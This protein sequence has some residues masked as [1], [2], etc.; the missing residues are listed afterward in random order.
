MVAIA[1]LRGTGDWGADERPKDFREMILWANPNGEAPLTA[2]MSK[3]G[4]EKLS[5]PE[6]AWWEETLSQQRIEFNGAVAPAAA[7]ATVYAA[8][9][10]TG[11]SVGAL[12]LGKG[13]V[14]MVEKVDGTGELLYIS[15]DPSNDTGISITKG[16]SGT[17]DA[18]IATGTI[19]L[20]IGS[21]FEEG[22]LQPKA[23]SSNPTKLYN[24]AQIF[25]TSYSITES[26][27]ATKART[28]NLLEIEKKRQAF[29]HSVK[30][31]LAYLWGK[32]SEIV[33]AGGKPLRTTGGLASMITSHRTTFTAGASTDF[34]VDNFLDAV[35]PCF[36]YD[37]A[38]AGNERIVFWGN[39]AAMELNKAIKNETNSR[40]NFEGTVKVYGMELQKVTLPMGTLYFKTHPLFNTHPVYKYSM[41]GINPKGVKDRFLRK[42]TFKDNTQPNDADYQSGYWIGE[43]GVELQHE[44][45][46]FL[47]S[48]CRSHA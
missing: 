33:G 31:E 9:A 43:S 45:T 40:I 25:K 29:K 3:M 30:M 42:T 10:G 8:G 48:D 23:R 6:F 37:A 2:L 26:A 13:D 22:T 32:R 21:A 16:F 14:L 17:T 27:K 4:S 36:D 35:S 1:G 44:R 11:V 24:Y 46:F 38:G 39:G 20:V 5:D 19:A 12:A 47:L 41:I 28:G 34:T 18:T 15:A 7:S